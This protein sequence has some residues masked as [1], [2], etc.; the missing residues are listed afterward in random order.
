MPKVFCTFQ[1][2]VTDIQ[3]LCCAFEMMSAEKVISDKELRKFLNSAAIDHQRICESDSRNCRPCSASG[4]LSSSV[5]LPVSAR[6]MGTEYPHE[7]IVRLTALQWRAARLIRAGEQVDRNMKML[8]K[9]SRKIVI[10]FMNIYGLQLCVYLVFVTMLDDWGTRLR[11]LFL[12]M[13]MLFIMYSIAVNGQKVK[14]M[15]ETLRL[16]MCQCEWTDKPAWF[17]KGILLMTTRSTREM[18]VRPYDLYTL[19]MNCITQL[20]DWGTRLRYLFLYMVMLFIMYS[21]AVNGQKV[22]DMGETL[23]LTMC[24][25]EWTDKPAWFRKGILIMTTRSTREMMCEPYDLYTLDMNCITQMDDQ[26][27]IDKKAFVEKPI[28]RYLNVIFTIL[29]ALYGSNLLL[30]LIY[31]GRISKLRLVLAKEIIMFCFTLVGKAATGKTVTGYKYVDEKI[32]NGHKLHRV[33]PAK[34]S[35]IIQRRNKRMKQFNSLINL[36]FGSAYLLIGFVP[37]VLHILKLLRAYFFETT[38]PIL[39]AVFHIYYPELLKDSFSYHVYSHTSVSLLYGL[40]V[41]FWYMPFKCAMLA[42]E[43]FMADIRLLAKSMELED[44]GENWEENSEN[45]IRNNRRNFDHTWLKNE[46]AKIVENHKNLYRDMEQLNELFQRVAVGFINFYALLADEEVLFIVKAPHLAQRLSL[47]F[48]YLIALS[49]MYACSQIGE[50][51]RE[52]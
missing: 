21:I 16:T 19:D 17:R 7:T 20:D 10:G 24:Q 33:S 40:T 1:C 44:C 29:A 23:R 51:I 45:D 27:T 28:P 22:K 46:M 30:A 48:R 31:Q 8:D 26:V 13:V 15:G 18:I 14:D 12:Y 35:R 50:N 2:L 38:I 52:E 39:P 4:T 5:T 34:T 42:G 47:S 11:Y 9:V 6:A 49:I 43:C 41:Y 25:C 37:Y 32:T 3:L 36:A